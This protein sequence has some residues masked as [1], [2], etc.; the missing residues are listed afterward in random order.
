MQD[1]KKPKRP[2][3]KEP[4]PWLLAAGPA[5]VVVAGLYTYKLAAD[6]D[7][8]LVVD[9][10]YKEGKEINLQLKRDEQATRLGVEAQ[11]MFSPDHK[12]VRLLLRSKVAL[13]EALTLHLLHPTLSKSDQTVLAKRIGEGMYEA[14]IAPT[15]AGH[16]YVRLEDPKAGW[17]IQ[18]EWKPQET[19]VV[20]LDP[21]LPEADK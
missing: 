10:Y 12:A 5:I 13:P 8:A 19:P 1:S 21:M 16:W 6:T 7:D 2:W 3:Y 15:A 4:W 14:V 20:R 11:A 17:R 18:G 9:D